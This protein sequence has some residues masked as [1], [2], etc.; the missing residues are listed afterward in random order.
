MCELS[1]PFPQPLSGMDRLADTI[2]FQASA[3]TTSEQE[4]VVDTKHIF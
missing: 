2:Y 1:G 3:F 4:T